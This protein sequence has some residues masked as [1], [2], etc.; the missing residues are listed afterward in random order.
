NGAKF[1]LTLVGVPETLI[2]QTSL[3]IK[4][5]ADMN[6][7]LASFPSLR[8]ADGRP[9]PQG[10]Y[11][12][13][14]TEADANSQPQ[15]VESVLSTLPSRSEMLPTESEVQGPRRLFLQKTYFLGGERDESYSKRLKDF[16]DRLRSRS[17]EELVELGDILQ[18]LT[19]QLSATI[20][21]YKKQFGGKPSKN[22]EK[23]WNEFH[24]KWTGSQTQLE[25]G[26]SGWAESINRKEF[27][28]WGLYQLIRTVSE[29]ISQLHVQQ[30]SGVLIRPND[31]QEF[32]TQLA[33]KQK[34]AQESL[35]SLE[36]KITESR[37]LNESGEG[38]PRRLN[39]SESAPT[40]DNS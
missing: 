17:Q 14:I 34:A 18:K 19:S 11:R 37:Q 16:H 25:Q 15:L 2:S 40:E 27:F 4:S 26:F 6:N 29:K 38:M 28:H 39:F 32:Q 22:A 30:H 10:E 12:I 31:V 8:Q 35:S 3:V 13:Y 33:E 36:S 23:K 20:D 5:S 24:E 7:K 1:D 9:L 21:E